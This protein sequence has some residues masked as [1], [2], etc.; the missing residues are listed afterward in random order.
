MQNQFV[1]GM[2]DYHPDTVTSAYSAEQ[3]VDGMYDYHPDT[4]TTPS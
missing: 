4:L 1:D 2:Y 3:F